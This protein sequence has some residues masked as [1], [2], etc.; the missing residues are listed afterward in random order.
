M[1]F[2]SFV[3]L[4]RFLPAVLLVYFLVPR[5]CKNLALFL[6]SLI[7]Y[8]W[9]EPLYVGLMIFSTVTDYIHGNLVDSFLN[10]NRRLAAKCAVASSVI[11]NVLL[12]GIFKYSD[13]LIQGINL[14]AHTQIPLPELPLPVGISFYTLQTMSYTIDIYRREARPATNIIDIGAFVAMFP[15]LVAGP[16]VRNETTDLQLRKR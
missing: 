10:Q 12:L 16:I 15:Q 13:L 14:A 3:F 6:A 9:G 11:I 4:F 5:I 1:V 2:S 8:A 7:F